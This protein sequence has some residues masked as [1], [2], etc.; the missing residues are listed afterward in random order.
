MGTAV[1]GLV[2]AVIGAAAGLIASYITA[3]Q[4]RQLEV[5]R[6]D[7][8]LDVERE[9]EVR[10]AVAEFA[11]EMSRVLQ[12]LSWFTWQAAWRPAVVSGGWVDAYDAEMKTQQ[13]LVMAS[14]SK[15]AAL[16]PAAYER[17]E[18]LV[19]EMFGADARVA[20]AGSVIDTEPEVAR[21]QIAEFDEPT[22]DLFKRFQSE[23]ASWALQ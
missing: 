7:A 14:L 2:A 13:P 9:R 15:L 16:S 23:P 17:F 4:Q 3:R 8:Q 6:L 1:V 19:S 20:R 10:L 21:A 18:P 12:A 5:A 22:D 11:T